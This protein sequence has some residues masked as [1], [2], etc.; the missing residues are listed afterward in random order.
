M[1][2]LP[3]PKLFP[4]PGVVSTRAVDDWDRVHNYVLL[5]LHR[6]NRIIRSLCGGGVCG[7]LCNRTTRVAGEVTDASKVAARTTRC[8]TRGLCVWFSVVTQ[9]TQQ[10]RCSR[11]ERGPDGVF[12]KSTARSP[13]APPGRRPRSHRRSR[14]CVQVS[15]R[16]GHRPCEL[17]NAVCEAFVELLHPQHP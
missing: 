4:K 16:R 6:S 13:D 2:D 3:E 7:D 11:P 17:E 15:W 12:G 14:Q 10:R 9:S 5:G 8:C 1:I